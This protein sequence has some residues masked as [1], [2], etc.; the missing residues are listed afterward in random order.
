MWP[1]EPG[2]PAGR[3]AG[4]RRGA[5]PAAD[6]V[7]GRLAALPPYLRGRP[8]PYIIAHRGASALL[9]ENS[10]P[11]FRR[12]LDEGAEA[13]ETDLW[14]S[15][16]GVLV[17]HH[18]ATVSR[19]TGA[20]GRVDRM[21][22]RE[23][24]R[25]TLRAPGE[26]GGSRTPS[27]GVPGLD[28]LLACMPPDRL[29]VLELKDPRFD[30]PEWAARLVD[31]IAPRIAAGTVVVAAFQRRRLATLR[32]VEPRLALGQ[33]APKG[34]RP[35]RHADFLGP[36][37]PLLLLNPWYVAAAQGRGQWVAPL[38][39]RLHRRLRRYLRQGVDAL[40]TADPA[41]TRAQVEALRG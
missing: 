38:D 4:G 10:L 41:A 21:T 6:L 9:P 23:L 22:A 37:W 36:F 7:A 24:G 26:V 13:L 16:D 31:R 34:L 39:P 2:R 1:A 18:D 19:M 25:L 29:L 12:A 5:G 3:E 11:A 20:A 33:I 15:G 32:A 30:R 14:F 40:L 35:V 27:A 8:R 28:E 17:C